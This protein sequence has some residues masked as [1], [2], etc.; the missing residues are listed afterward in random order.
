MDPLKTKRSTVRNL[1]GGKRPGWMVQT[2]ELAKRELMELVRNPAIMRVRLAQT[3]FTGILAGIVF[4]GLGKKYR[5]VCIVFVIFDTIYGEFKS[6]ILKI[7]ITKY[8]FS[9]FIM[10]IFYH[11]LSFLLIYQM[12]RKQQNFSIKFSRFFFTTFLLKSNI[13]LYFIFDIW[14]SKF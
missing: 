8:C 13:Q 3:I 11:M 2:I 4:F 5:T 6:P 7:K 9:S 1:K 10:T 14:R 12:R